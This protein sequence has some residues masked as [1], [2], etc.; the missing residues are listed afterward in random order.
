MLTRRVTKSSKPGSA[1]KD[2][3]PLWPLDAQTGDRPSTLTGRASPTGSQARTQ[4]T[5]TAPRGS[6]G[7]NPRSTR[8]LVGLLASSRS[9]KARSR[10][11]APFFYTAKATKREATLDGQVPNKHPTKKPLAIM[12]WLVRLGCQKGGLVIDPYC[13]VSGTTCV[14]AVEE[15]SMKFIGIE[16]DDDYYPGHREAPVEIVLHREEALA[17]SLRCLRREIMR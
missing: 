6:V 13:R 11:D 12:Q 9:S 15:G 2:V 4:E 5:T 8:T 17:G 1:W 7:A 3:P 14:A 16:K 10:S